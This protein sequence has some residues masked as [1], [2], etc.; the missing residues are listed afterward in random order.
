MTKPE[1]DGKK[2][3]CEAMIPDYNLLPIETSIEISVLCKSQAY[4]LFAELSIN[5]RSI[6]KHRSVEIS[7]SGE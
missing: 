4:M 2:L 1:D 5:H 6:E 7:A 3:S